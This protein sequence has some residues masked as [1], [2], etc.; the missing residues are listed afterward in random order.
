MTNLESKLGQSLQALHDMLADYASK[1][2]CILPPTPFILTIGT[3]PGADTRKR[4][5]GTIVADVNKLVSIFEPLPDSPDKITRIEVNDRLPLGS[6][7]FYAA[8]L[9]GAAAIATGKTTR[10]NSETYFGEGF[11]DNAKRL[12]LDKD[13]RTVTADGEAFRNVCESE[14]TWPLVARQSVEKLRDGGDS[15]AFTLTLQN[16]K[17]EDVEGFSATVRVSKPAAE[18]LV[19]AL[20]AGARIKLKAKKAPAEPV[21]IDA[22]PIEVSPAPVPKAKGK[23]IKEVRVSA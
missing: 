23:L 16:V 10:G 15:V 18:V 11:T 22:A 20:T 4:K 1:V 12:G 21:T 17:G 7:D 14:I 5:N 6:R 19:A 8:I 3:P 9:H 2:G 13:K